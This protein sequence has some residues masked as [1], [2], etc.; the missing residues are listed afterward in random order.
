MGFFEGQTDLEELQPPVK[1]LQSP[2]FFS[3]SDPGSLS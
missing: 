2:V 3:V 1:E